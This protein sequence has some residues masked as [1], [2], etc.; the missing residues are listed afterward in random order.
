MQN[1]KKEN[2]LKKSAEKISFLGNYISQALNV[3]ITDQIELSTV[4]GVFTLKALYAALQARST[5]PAE[6]HS[7]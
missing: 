4:T 1:V 7:T 2:F 5:S 6:A 3:R